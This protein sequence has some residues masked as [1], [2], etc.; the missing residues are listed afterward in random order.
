MGTG[1]GLLL[2]H[3]STIFCISPS[4]S[5]QKRGGLLFGLFVLFLDGMGGFHSGI[6]RGAG[7]LLGGV[8][9][10][11][12]TS[13]TKKH[14]ASQGR[15]LPRGV[16]QCSSLQKPTGW[17]KR[18]SPQ[19]IINVCSFKPHT[20]GLNGVN[21]LCFYSTNAVV[22]VTCHW[23]PRARGTRCTCSSTSSTS[24]WPGNFFKTSPLVKGSSE[25]GD[26]LG[27]KKC[28]GHGWCTPSAA[29]SRTAGAENPAPPQRRSP[30]YR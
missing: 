8:A 29:R 10:P 17:N 14:Y 3:W 5:L 24:S 26:S 23:V 15:I 19:K 2:G 27:G 25:V 30:A 9:V 6:D 18:D 16:D 22:L 21:G 20:N 13:E 1:A 11:A 4:D 12:Q 7:H 28:P